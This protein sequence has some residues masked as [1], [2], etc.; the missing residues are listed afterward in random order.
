MRRGDVKLLDK[1]GAGQFGDV[2]KGTVDEQSSTGVPEYLVAVKV[3]H[4]CICREIT[5]S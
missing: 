4:D 1:L 5:Y 3:S 2:F